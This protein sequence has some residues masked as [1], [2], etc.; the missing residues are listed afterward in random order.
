MK[1]NI[2]SGIA[3]TSCFLLVIPA[4]YTLAVLIMPASVLV[5]D[6]HLPELL[7]LAAALLSD[8]AGSSTLSELRIPL[9]AAGFSMAG[10]LSGLINRYVRA[11]LLCLVSG[12]GASL[13]LAIAVP[14][15][16]PHLPTA[17]LYM[18]C[19]GLGMAMALL[20]RFRLF[21]AI[22]Q[23]CKGDLSPEDAWLWCSVKDQDQPVFLFGADKTTLRYNKPARDLAV[24]PQNVATALLP[25]AG[26]RRQRLG[27]EP[28]DLRPTR[29]YAVDWLH[30]V[31]NMCRLTDIS[32]AY[33]SEQSLRKAL[34][35]DALTGIVNRLGFEQELAALRQNPDKL[36]YAIFYIDLNGFKAVNDT[37]GHEAGDHILQV[38]AQRFCAVAYDGHSVCR[39]G[40]DE[41]G[42]VVPHRMSCLRAQ[43]YAETLEAALQAPILFRTH[44]LAVGAAVGF[45]LPENPNETPDAVLRR[46]DQSMYRRKA[47]LKAN[48]R[49]SG[50]AVA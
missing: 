35:T 49:S 5:I 38:A 30:P 16:E 11:I 19:F 23:Y 17:Q 48:N 33:K 1:L 47:L 43:T 37:H 18:C 14:S 7:Q 36:A 8:I 32:K 27:I 34:R 9:L 29:I 28:D 15:A 21:Q 2:H 12:I 6:S 45:G 40:G 26:K 3:R 25:G 31:R 46:A 42:I 13:S 50:R 20:G 44:Q 22:E 4:S 10:L 41:F 24:C 39:L